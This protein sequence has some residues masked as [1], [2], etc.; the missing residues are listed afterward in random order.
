VPRPR[1]TPKGKGR[2]D[3]GPAALPHPVGTNGLAVHR[4]RGVV[5]GRTDRR[6]EA[7]HRGD[8]GDGDQGGDQT[9]FDRGGALAVSDQL[10]NALHVPVSLVPLGFRKST[11]LAARAETGSASSPISAQP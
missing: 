9:I 1:L 8:G 7:L 10:A 6:A 3:R 2:R 11:F 5:E 4:R